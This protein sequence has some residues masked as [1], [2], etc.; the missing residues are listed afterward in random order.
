MNV[1]AKTYRPKA[2]VIFYN[3]KALLIFLSLSIMKLGAAIVQWVD[4][5]AHLL[6]CRPGFTSQ[7]DQLCFFI[8]NQTCSLFVFSIW[9]GTKKQKEAGFGPHLKKLWCY[10]TIVKPF[11]S[12]SLPSYNEN[13]PLL[14]FFG[15]LFF[16]L[17]AVSLFFQFS[18][19]L[20][21]SRK[22]FFPL[23]FDWKSM[24]WQH[25]TVITVILSAFIFM[26]KNHS[27]KP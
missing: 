27:V 16:S 2:I 9:K 17:A 7:A 14:L 10:F 12:F 15:C 3:I 19:D 11:C 23:F 4:S 26:P 22:T 25:Q 6:S 20:P 13:F 5:P 21:K 1:F 24:V 18:L 8:Y